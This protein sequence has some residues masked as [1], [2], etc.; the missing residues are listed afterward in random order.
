MDSIH[1]F[2]SPEGSGIGFV[3]V[4]IVILSWVVAHYISWNFP[5]LLQHVQKAVSQPLRLATLNRFSPSERYTKEQISP[6]LWPNGKRPTRE[7]W[8]QM[9]ADKFRTYKL[10]IDGLV[11]RSVELSLSD[12]AA[13][14]KPNTLPCTT[15]FKVG[16]A[17]RNG[18][19]CQ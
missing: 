12:W 13:L 8:K 6:Y 7:D 3:G 16:Q 9:A 18:E 5:R 19:A 10:K 15:A 1:A 2:A 4:G 14:G 11:D 17:L